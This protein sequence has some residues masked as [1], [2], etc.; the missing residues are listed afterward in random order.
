MPMWSV[1]IHK[2][3]HP[4]DP[5]HIKSTVTV[6]NAQKKYV[7][8]NVNLNLYGGD[9]RWLQKTK[10]LFWYMSFGQSVE[11]RNLFWMSI[12]CYFY[13]FKCGQVLQFGAQSRYYKGALTQKR[14]FLWFVLL[15]SFCVGWKNQNKHSTIN[16]SFNTL[17][18]WH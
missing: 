5:T 8:T 6:D 16:S 2:K 10:K 9:C 18:K 7:W 3:K 11:F 15:S 4:T 12:I 13:F 14:S 1:V 17:S